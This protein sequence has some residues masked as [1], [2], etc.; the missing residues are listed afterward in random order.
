MGPEVQKN[1]C[2][3]CAYSVERYRPE[4][5]SEEFWK[6]ECRRFPPQLS[7]R[8]AWFSPLVYPDFACGEF[9]PAELE[10]ESV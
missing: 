1:S 3:R 5:Q 8:D 7:G 2:A 10:Q 9:K 4:G 6:L